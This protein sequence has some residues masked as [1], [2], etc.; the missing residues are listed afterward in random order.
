M[1]TTN[2][3]VATRITTTFV[4]PASESS[5]VGYYASGTAV[6]TIVCG[7]DYEFLVS[8]T[9]GVCCPTNSAGNC[10]FR[11]SCQASMMVYEDG[12]T[13]TCENNNA[14][15]ETTIFQR[16]PS[17]G[18]SAT[19][20]WCIDED[21]PTTIYR[22][23]VGTQLTLVPAGSTAI[24]TSSDPETTDTTTSDEIPTVTRSDSTMST[25]TTTSITGSSEPQQTGGSEPDSDDGPNVGAIA[26]GVVGGVA[27]LVL[28]ILAAWFVM[29]RQK[30]KNAELR[31]IGTTYVAPEAK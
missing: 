30:Q 24:T 2:D 14:C 6:G 21:N 13:F 8:S 20:A 5:I 12:S 17:A 1:T 28:I 3:L 27:G 7:S 11:Q 16:Q 4:P 9:Y 19:M 22:S 26:G 25:T 23:F 15:V 10:G 29:R 18:W 31:E